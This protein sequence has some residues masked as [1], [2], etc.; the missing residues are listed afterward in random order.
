ME[1][2]QA[3]GY[4][5]GYRSIACY[6]FPE[7]L[8]IISSSLIDRFWVSFA[9]I[10]ECMQICYSILMTDVADSS[11]GL[12]IY[13]TT[14]NKHTR[15]RRKNGGR[16]YYTEVSNVKEFINWATS[17]HRVIWLGIPTAIDQKASSA[18]PIFKV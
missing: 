5:T 12:R 10:L 16:E 8:L 15:K 2:G 4:D 11:N 3:R 9:D 17:D 1:Q 7:M 13:A 18:S 14:Q 6:Y